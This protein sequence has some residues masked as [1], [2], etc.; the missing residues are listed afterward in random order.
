MAEGLKAHHKGKNADMCKENVDILRGLCSEDSN[1]INTGRLLRMLQAE[2]N[3]GKGGDDVQ[4]GFSFFR[5]RTID[6]LIVIVE[7][8]FSSI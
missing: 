8:F 5:V 1:D 3:R 6:S 2:E 4:W 7:V